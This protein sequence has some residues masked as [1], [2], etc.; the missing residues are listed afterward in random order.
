[1]YSPGREAKRHTDKNCPVQPRAGVD[2]GPIHL[3]DA[4]LQQQ[5]TDLGWNVNFD[6]HHQ[7]E[8]IDAQDDTQLGIL[9]RPR[10]VSRVTE[11]VAEVVGGHARKGELPLTLGGDHSLVSCFKS[12]QVCR[13]ETFVSRWE[14]SRVF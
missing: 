10:L 2:R 13:N 7:F 4:G 5:L 9:K 8:D 6:G 1:V 12:S 14:L 11:A 3:V